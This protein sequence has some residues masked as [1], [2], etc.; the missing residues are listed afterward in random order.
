MKTK[1]ILIVSIFVIFIFSLFTGLPF[2][3]EDLIAGNLVKENKILKLQVDSLQ[4]RYD[5]L[6]YQVSYLDSLNREILRTSISKI[7]SLKNVIPA[8]DS[9][10]AN[11]QRD[12][13]LFL[14]SL[15]YKLENLSQSGLQ[16]L[17]NLQNR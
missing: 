8:K 16:N 13:I 14:D 2:F 1:V 11:S 4:S 7:D 17:I 9:I 15:E 12:F 10:I 3:M 5:D 6:N